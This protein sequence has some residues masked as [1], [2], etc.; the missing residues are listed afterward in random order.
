[1]KF[2]HNLE[3]D[4][5]RSVLSSAFYFLSYVDFSGVEYMELVEI[6][7]S[8]TFSASKKFREPK[9]LKISN[10]SYKFRPQL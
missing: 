5:R 6:R 7:V 10:F 4:L 9:I 2:Q 3:R 8:F 1:M